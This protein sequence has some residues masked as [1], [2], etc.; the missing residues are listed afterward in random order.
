MHSL[1]LLLV[2]TLEIKT[3]SSLPLSLLRDVSDSQQ[4]FK[5]SF[6]N[7]HA[8]LNAFNSHYFFSSSLHPE[9]VHV[10]FLPFV[11]DDI[12]MPPFEHL[13][14]HKAFSSRALVQYLACSG[15]KEWVIE[16]I[17]S[18]QNHHI[19][20]RHASKGLKLQESKRR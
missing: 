15:L 16:D 18:T 9:M 3:T 10:F 4:L 8:T 12:P 20:L 5:A 2:L 19:A 7:G 11:S 6:H 13:G 1:D 17:T 14:D